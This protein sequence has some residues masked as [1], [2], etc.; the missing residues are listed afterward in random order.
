MPSSGRYREVLD[1]GD[2]AGEVVMLED[3]TTLVLVVGAGLRCG[4]NS[5]VFY[6]LS[7]VRVGWLGNIGALNEE[8]WELKMRVAVMTIVTSNATTLTSFGFALAKVLEYS[9]SFIQK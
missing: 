2:V 6:W 1:C 7:E 8:R 9:S 4:T 5:R 3:K